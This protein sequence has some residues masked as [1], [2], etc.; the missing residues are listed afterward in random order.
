ME[1]I[2]SF[3]GN[4]HV[5]GPLQEAFEKALERHGYHREV[6]AG[7][8]GAPHVYEY[9]KDGS[10]ISVS[11]DDTAGEKWQAALVVETE[12]KHEDV[13]AVVSESVLKL[14]ADLS[15]RLIESVSDAATRVKIADELRGVLASLK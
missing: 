4:R 9:K 8:A 15:T 1:K 13:A 2:Y 3:L 6:E 12:S 11:I 7:G 10:V 14:L 5:V